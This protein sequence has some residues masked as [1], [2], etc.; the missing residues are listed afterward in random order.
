MLTFPSILVIVDACFDLNRID[1]V[2]EQVGRK[3]YQKYY[4][5]IPINIYVV[6]RC[7]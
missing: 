2:L 7:S 3:H 1:Y 4:L 6:M 5:I